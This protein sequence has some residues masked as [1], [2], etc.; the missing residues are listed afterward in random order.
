[1]VNQGKSVHRNTEDKAAISVVLKSR[2]QQ[3]LP[4]NN[5]GIRHKEF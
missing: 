2:N 4:I 1:M 3:L 5:V